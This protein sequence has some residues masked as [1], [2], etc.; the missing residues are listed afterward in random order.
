MGEVKTHVA[1]APEFYA[2]GEL[3]LGQGCLL[4]RV[5]FETQPSFRL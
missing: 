5:T 4:R 1:R 3:E 2:R